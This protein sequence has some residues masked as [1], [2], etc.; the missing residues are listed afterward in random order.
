MSPQDNST[1]GIKATMGRLS[2][3]VRSYDDELAYHLE[4]ENKVGGGCCLLLLLVLAAVA[5]A[6][7]CCCCGCC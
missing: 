2:Q 5:L 4:S 1:V 7:A 3:F 6:A